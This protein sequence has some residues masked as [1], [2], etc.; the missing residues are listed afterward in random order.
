MNASPLTS[1]TPADTPA[2][3]KP[4]QELPLPEPVSWAPQTIGWAAVSVLL[5]V[6]ALWAAW[7]GWRRYKREHYRR[8]ALAELADIEVALSDAQRRTVALAAIP[9][10]IKR[11]SLAA[12]PRERVAP[13]SGDE[14]LAFLKRTRGRFDERSGALLTLVS[15]APAEQIASIT[16]LEVET[17]VSV[18]RD[19]IQRHHVEI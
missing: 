8:V 16:P 5:I 10:L 2:A 12:A 11:T 9:S 3:L 4:L 14:W 19:W 6:A 1:L 7:M 18:T 15:Y 17:L 13:L